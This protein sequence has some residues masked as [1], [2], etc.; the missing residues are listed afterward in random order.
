MHKSYGASEANSKHGPGHNLSMTI[1]VPNSVSS[2]LKEAYQ[3]H[4]APSTDTEAHLAGAL[5]DTLQHP[6]NMIRAELAFRLGQS[7]DLPDAGS[8]LIAIAIEYFHSASLLF[9][10]L[11]CMDD[12]MLRRGAACVHRTYG[13]GAAIL[14]AL[15]LINRAYGLLWQGVAGTSRDARTRALAYAERQL[16]MEGLLNGQSRDLHLGEASRNPRMYRQIAMGKTVSL[17]QMALVVPAIA[18]G[19]SESEQCLLERLAVAWGLCYQ[20]LDDI[21]DVLHV[22]EEG[23]KTAARDRELHRPNLALTIGTE[24]S[25]RRAHRLV[26]ISE[27]LVA[28]L[29][30]QHSSML[31]LK[32]TLQR[33]REEMAAIPMPALVQKL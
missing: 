4:C 24:A 30:R 21:K 11:P 7:Y 26:N 23:G 25:F 16:G 15:V 32:E 29:L 6:G 1:A 9:D 12:A 5:Q 28:R 17:I 19:A 13:E 33:F 18:G 22:N 27:Q 3:R 2:R 8:E 31:F 14:T 10:D 20:I